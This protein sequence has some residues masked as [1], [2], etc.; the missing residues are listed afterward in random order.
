ML[1]PPFPK[2]PGHRLIW[3]QLH[4]SALGLILSNAAKGYQGLLVVTLEDTASV[5]RLAQELQFYLGVTEK[6]PV[7]IFPD[8]ETLP[9]DPFSPHQDIV[10]ERL[11]TLY[12][13][14]HLTKGILLVPAATLM[15][16]LPPRDYLDKSTLTVTPGQRL[17]LE[18]LHTY[19]EN[20]G[21]RPVSTVLER[22][23]FTIHGER[24]DLY[25]MGTTLPCRIEFKTN[26]VSSLQNFDPETQRSQDSISLIH[27]LPA[28]ELPLDPISISHFQK[29]WLT[30]FPDK[31]AYSTCRDVG[32]GLSPSG[33]EYYLP[34]F[35]EQTATLFDYLP[36]NSVVVENAGL[37]TSMDAFWQ[38]ITKRYES[39]RIVRPLLSPTTLYLQTHQVFGA[40][41]GY[42]RVTAHTDPQIIRNGTTNFD[43]EVPPTLS[44]E[45][46]SENPF[47]PFLDFSTTR[48]VLVVAESAGRR[49][50]L[51]GLLKTVDLFPKSVSGWQKFLENNAPLAITVAPLEQGLCLKGIAVIVENQL[52]GEQ[53]MQRRRRDSKGLNPEAMIRDLVELRI[54]MPIV[55][56]THGVGRYLG[57]QHLSVDGVD[58]EFLSLEYEGGDKL[59]VPIS[60]LNLVS[61]YTGLDSEHAPLHKL[62]S[63]QWEKAKRR[64]AEQARDVA[65]E[66]LDLHARR[67]ARVGHT[68]SVQPTEYRAFCAGFPFET[69]PD[70]QDAIDATLADLASSLPMD[71]VICGDVGFGKTEIALRAAFVVV[72]EGRQVAVLV[73]TTLLA[74]QHYQ[75]FADRFADWPVRVE[76]MSRFRTPKQQE[77]VLAGLASGVV[78]IVIGT[79]KLLQTKT[80]FQSLGLVILDEEHRFGVRQKEALKALRTSVDLLTLTATPIPRTL[81]MAISGLREF[82]IL[83]TPPAKRLAIQTFIQSWEDDLLRE[84]MLRE[85]KRGGQVYFLHNEVAT[86]EKIAQKVEDLLPEATV[87]VAHGQMRER[88]LE[89][90]M[91]DFYHQRFNVLVCSTIIETGIDIPTA[92]TI[93]LHRAD[94]LGLAQLYQLRGRVGR[95]HHRAYAYLIVPERKAMTPEAIKRLDAI[96]SLEDLGVGFALA[97]HDMEIRGAGELLGEAQSGQMQEVGFTLYQTFLKNA[98]QA[99]RSGKDLSSEPPLDLSS[100]VNLHISAL[101]PTEYLP[102]V[103]IRLILYKRIASAET[104]GELRELR[105]E[106][107]DR[108]GLFPKQVE[109]LFRVAEFKLT[110]K[111]LG[112]QKLDFGATGGHIQFC[113]VPT[114]DSLAV[115]FLLQNFPKIY[116]MDRK[117]RL[118]ISVAM[119]AAETRFSAA[120]YL[121]WVLSV[122][123]PKGEPP[124]PPP[125]LL[126]PYV[127]FTAEMRPK[128]NPRKDK[129]ASRMGRPL[130]K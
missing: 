4:G 14:P 9:Y 45:T 22:G 31:I 56:E 2:N 101:I 42:P 38:E 20:I 91:L 79:H 90:V 100:E 28:K 83:S 94:R 12:Q 126:N 122:Q 3:G 76:V 66:L 44:V 82:S 107:V 30:T 17:T 39:G 109:N 117:E 115:V 23:E 81:H 18:Q 24:I 63:S 59:Y 46:R 70:Q 128:Q 123:K 15:Q 16:R 62:G 98:V 37:E 27:V 74:Q 43:T 47:K 53:A 111:T 97:T 124:E 108:F 77:E 112:I 34:L 116:Q 50:T 51:L 114:I 29:N 55:H 21:Y 57:L 88:D 119:P 99:I 10:S 7:F 105:V 11:A 26:S 125:E 19:L 36:S 69:T 40:L 93:I 127:P 85:I 61:R 103:H 92:N 121:L 86:I 72:E 35:F 25:S 41:N 13:L 49:E 5:F 68:F 113:P 118:K 89:R 54:G 8:W 104:F 130:L 71:R 80:V 52:F 64:A 87:R 95:S 1:T 67:A 73:P 32:Q 106:M 129:R 60:A 33:I 48:R 102:D 110:T 58:A 96:A 65:V 6:T 78:N 120:E 84:A 75:T